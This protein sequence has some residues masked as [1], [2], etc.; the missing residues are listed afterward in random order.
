MIATNTWV[1]PG[2]YEGREGNIL[3]KQAKIVLK[4]I[5]LNI[6]LNDRIKK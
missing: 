5:S 3:D 2:F 1:D 4:K 6:R